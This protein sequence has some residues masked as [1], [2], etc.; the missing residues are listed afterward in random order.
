MSESGINM[1]TIHTPVHYIN[2]APHSFLGQWLSSVSRTRL[3]SEHSIWGRPLLALFGGHRG[4]RIP[5]ERSRNAEVWRHLTHLN[6]VL[7][8]VVAE[9]TGPGAG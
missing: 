7:R 2:S 6:H 4:Q 1:Y 5:S 9:G 3:H 8:A